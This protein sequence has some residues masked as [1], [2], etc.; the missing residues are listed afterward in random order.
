MVA[1]ISN[2]VTTLGADLVLDVFVLENL[3]FSVGKAM[4]ITSKQASYKHP[5]SVIERKVF[6][7]TIEE[8]CLM[9][10]NELKTAQLTCCNTDS[11]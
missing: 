2:Q 9:S 1:H 10:F 4:K 11:S 3:L 7:K 5:E 8:L 6:V